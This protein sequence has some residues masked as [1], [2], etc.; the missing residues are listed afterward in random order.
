MFSLLLLLLLMNQ[1]DHFCQSTTPAYVKQ[2][3]RCT[4]YGHRP[5]VVIPTDVEEL[6]GLQWAG[7]SP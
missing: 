6:A 2:L 4:Q 1:A 7:R 3:A 5:S